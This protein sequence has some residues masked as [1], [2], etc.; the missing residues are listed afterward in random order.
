MDDLPAD[1]AEERGS[2]CAE[3]VAM[4][5]VGDVTLGASARGNTYGEN[6]GNGHKIRANMRAQLN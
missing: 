4:P 2:L 5:P 3:Q 1:S 6:R